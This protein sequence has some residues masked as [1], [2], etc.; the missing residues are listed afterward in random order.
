VIERAST[1]R[2]GNHRQHVVTSSHVAPQLERI[3]TAQRRAPNGEQREGAEGQKSQTEAARRKEMRGRK[4][5]V[6]G[7]LE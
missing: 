1:G 7:G 3:T 5:S 2:R 4:S 6:E